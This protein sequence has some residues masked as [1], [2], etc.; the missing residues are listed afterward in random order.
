M[1]NSNSTNTNS[2]SFNFQNNI[3]R[4]LLNTYVDMYNATLRDIDRLYDILDEIRHSIHN[5]EINRRNSSATA[6]HQPRARNSNRRSETINVPFET[7]P[8]QIYLNGR[9]Y[10]VEYVRP[11]S[12]T[13]TR[14]RDFFQNGIYNILDNLFTQ[15]NLQ[16]FN[17]A[18][19]VRPSAQEIQNA[20]INT[21]FSSIN[22][23]I[24]SSC[25]IS[26]ERFEDDAEV[27]QIVHC[28]HVFNTSE[29]NIWFERNV[30]CPV[31][32]YDIRRYSRRSRHSSPTRETQEENTNSNSNSNPLQENANANAN[33][34]ANTNANVQHIPNVLLQNENISNI[35]YNENGDITFDISMNPLVNFATQ[36]LND[37]IRNPQSGQSVNNFFD[38][39]NNAI[40]LLETI[41]RRQP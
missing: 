20:T 13:E 1:S 14:R 25:P 2:N 29:L 40:L 17:D 36:A 5:L 7:S 3:D 16:N 30:R 11:N 34:N 10:N 22:D 26:L 15:E 8:N 39:S 24:N 27:T 33:A 38:P 23:P 4:A 35:Q 28:G 12:E 18:I 41:L 32:R 9:H 21:L 6:R 19:I 37:L 31:C